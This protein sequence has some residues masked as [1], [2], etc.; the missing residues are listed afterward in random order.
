MEITSVSKLVEFAETCPGESYLFRGQRQDKELLPK[1]ARG[2][3]KAN[4]LTEERRLLDDFRIR[5]APYLPVADYDDWEL[6]AI[7]QH[8][9]MATRLLDWT[10]NALAALYFAVREESKNREDG[11]LWILPFSS[12][13]IAKQDKESPLMEWQQTFFDQSI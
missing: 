7:A 4:F 13:S 5:S 9:G 10:Q 12:E 8:N 6:L 11:V 3:L 1:I 2:T